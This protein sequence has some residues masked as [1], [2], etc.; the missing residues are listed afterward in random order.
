MTKIKEPNELVHE[1]SGAWLS[2][3]RR[4]IIPIAIVNA[5]QEVTNGHGDGV[6]K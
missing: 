1:A 4:K 3:C 6:T 5:E 2:R